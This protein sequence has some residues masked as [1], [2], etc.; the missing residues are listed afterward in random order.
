LGKVAE[1]CPNSLKGELWELQYKTRGF[2][3]L[4]K[5]TWWQRKSCSAVR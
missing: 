5:V 1:T 4:Q 2:L 3:E